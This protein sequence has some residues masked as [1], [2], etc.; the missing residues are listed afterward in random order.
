MLVYVISHTVFY[1]CSIY[2]S[3]TSLH[4][5]L[6]PEQVDITSKYITSLNDSQLLT[7]PNHKSRQFKSDLAQT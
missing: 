5:L 3:D 2:W 7:P 1:Y 6:F 4:R